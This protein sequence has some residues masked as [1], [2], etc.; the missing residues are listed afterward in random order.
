[1]DRWHSGY[2]PFCNTMSCTARAV[3]RDLQQRL[4]KRKNRKRSHSEVNV[5]VGLQR[6]RV[7]KVP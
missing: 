6:V 4:R 5:A 3:R 1:M 7:K 2:S